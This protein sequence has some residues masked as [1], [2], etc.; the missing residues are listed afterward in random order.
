MLVVNGKYLGSE[1]HLGYDGTF[2][3]KEIQEDDLVFG[4]HKYSIDP[5]MKMFGEQPPFL[6]EEKYQKMANVLG[7]NNPYYFG[8]IGLP[9]KKRLKEIIP[10]IF[11]F[12]KKI[13]N[14]KYIPTYK[15]TQDFLYSLQP[16]IANITRFR[17]L[18][19]MNINYPGFILKNGKFPKVKYNRA[20]TKTG[21]LTV[22]SGPNCL[23]MKSEHRNVIKGKSI[24]FSS[25]EPRLLLA[26]IGKTVDGDLYD[27]AAKEL[28]INGDRSYIKVSIISSMYGSRVVPEISRLFALDEWVSQLESEVSDG[29]IENYFGRPIEVKK[30]IGRKLLA[31]WLQSTAV[32]ASLLGFANLVESSN[33]IIPHWVIHDGLIISGSGKIPDKLQIIE[34]IELPVTVSEL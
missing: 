26:L 17:S 32:D 4:D 8:L 11:D 21:R 33:D 16:A 19:A 7:L 30:T 6:V 29:W 10:N 12:Y 13:E 24:D 18:E 20:H 22:A 34:G 31:L 9:Y 1:N 23:T 28:N 2:S 27:W 5:L 15:K 3:W 14:H 25:M